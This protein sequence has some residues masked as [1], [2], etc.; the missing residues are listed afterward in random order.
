MAQLRDGGGGLLG[1]G[2][3]PEGLGGRHGADIAP[4]PGRQARGDQA[5][6]A[7]ADD[8]DVGALGHQRSLRRRTNFSPDHDSSMAITLTSTSPAA[9]PASRT[10][11]SPRSA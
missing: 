3:P 7:A 10:S 6:V 8:D 2:R 4:G 9:S 5:V 11:F 1:G